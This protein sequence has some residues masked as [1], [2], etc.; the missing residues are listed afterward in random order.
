MTAASQP[1]K[2]ARLKFTDRLMFNAVLTENEDLCRRL[3]QAVLGKPVERVEFVDD[4]VSIQPDLDARGARLDVLALI[5]G[6]YVDVEMQVGREPSIARRCRFYH[7]AIASRFTPKGSKYEDV[8]KSYVIFICLDDPLGAGLPRYELA[9]TCTNS[10]S[11]TVDD[12][13]FTVLLN[14]R[15]WELEKNR[16]VAG[17]LKYALT[18]D[19]PEGLARDIASAVDGKNGDRKWVRATMS[20]MTY[21]D[22]MDLLNRALEIRQEKLDKV[23]A[24]LVETTKQLDAATAQLDA[25]TAQLDAATAQAQAR[26]DSLARLSKKLYAQGRIE[27]YLAALDNPELMDALLAEFADAR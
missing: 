11:I 5:D 19:S 18:G 10:P 22:E 26:A 7:A 8:P 23:S 13:A 21:G 14:A 15:A 6:E 3:I 12:G 2:L 9:T 25:A 4:E 16:E 27:E 17:M 1:R 24:Q 20:I